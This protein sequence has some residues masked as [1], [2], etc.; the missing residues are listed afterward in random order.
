MQYGSLEVPKK[1]ITL[2][3]ARSCLHEV[4]DHEI[5]PLSHPD[6]SV[7]SMPDTDNEAS[8]YIKRPRISSYRHTAARTL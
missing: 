1:E 5:Y 4:P 2:D 3:D 6:L 8:L 7:A